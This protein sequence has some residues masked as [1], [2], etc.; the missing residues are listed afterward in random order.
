MCHLQEFYAKYKSKGLVLLGL[1]TADHKQIALD[2]MRENGVAFPNILDASDAAKTVAHRDYPDAGCPTNYIIDRDGKVVDAWPGNDERHSRV[3]AALQKTGGQLAEAIH[4]EAIAKAAIAAPEVAAAA[5]RLF[6]VLRT[7][8]YDHEGISTRDC[9]HRPAKEINYNPS[10]NDPGWVRWVCKKF[11]A[12][13]ITDVQIGK[14][15]AGADGSPTTHF[16]LRLKDGEVLQGDLPFHFINWGPGG[17]QWVGE[18]ALDW[19]LRPPP[20]QHTNSK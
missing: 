5:Q 18:G 4:Q 13:P 9:K 2:F 6:E 8:D 16:A 17:K 12:N 3:I 20:A 15:V 7:A 19:H 10:R 1:N 11:K 14:V